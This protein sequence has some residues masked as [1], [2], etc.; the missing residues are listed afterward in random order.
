MQAID[1]IGI[2]SKIVR[3]HLI[4]IKTMK[5]LP[6]FAMALVIFAAAA[7]AQAGTWSWHSDVKPNPPQEQQISYYGSVLAW[8][9]VNFSQ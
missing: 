5:K 8:F 6:L 4:R 2:A 1:F 9:K 3:Q 7:Q